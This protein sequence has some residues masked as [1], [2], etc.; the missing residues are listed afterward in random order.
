MLFWTI[1]QKLMATCSRSC[2]DKNMGSFWGC[3]W[4]IPWWRAWE[5]LCLVGEEG[6]ELRCSKLSQGW[7]VV[8]KDLLLPA[9]TV[10]SFTTTP[11]GWVPAWS[12]S[13][14]ASLILLW[15]STLGYPLILDSVPDEAWE[16]CSLSPVYEYGLQICPFAR[17]DKN[18]SL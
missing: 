9:F 7:N 5:V 17:Q 3:F 11:C 8:N 16:Y 4:L 14:I 6:S 18:N 2:T 13:L 15:K 1:T 12:V 10:E